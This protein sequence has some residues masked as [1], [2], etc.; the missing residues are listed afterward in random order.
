MAGQTVAK[1]NPVTYLLEGLRS[2][3]MVGWDTTELA[4]RSP[5]SRSSG[6][7]ASLGRSSAA[8]PGPRSD[9]GA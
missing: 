1:Y 6:W 8:F 4:R 2:L 3:L 7:S 9:P 5:P